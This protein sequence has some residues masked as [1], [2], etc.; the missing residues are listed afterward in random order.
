MPDNVNVVSNTTTG[1][2]LT[3]TSETVVATVIVPATTNV[4]RILHF[5]ANC[6]LTAGAGTTAV[7]LRVRRDG[8]AGTLVVGP[9]TEPA[10]AS[11]LWAGSAGGDDAPGEVA[12]RTYVLTAQQTGAT[13]NGTGATGYLC[14]IVD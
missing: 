9:F 11:A 10:T 5:L 14:C 2:T 1:T 6:V 8:V 12:S 7:A 4:Q 13:G 3:T